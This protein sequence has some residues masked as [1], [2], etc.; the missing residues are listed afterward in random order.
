[1]E[2]IKKVCFYG[3][4][5]TGKTF[6]AK[7]LAEKYKTEFV[8][9]VAREFITTNNFNREDIIVIGRAQTERI[10]LKA[11]TANK[12]LFCDTDLITTQIYSRQYLK[13]VPPVLYELEKMVEFDRYF[14]FDIDVPW[15][16]DGLRDLGDEKKREEMYAIFKIEL[17][18]RNI[19]YVKVQGDWDEREKIIVREVAK[20]IH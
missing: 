2:E 9:E 17:E 5:S 7:K 6:M 1:M 20:L 18:R 16:S 15:V 19:P 10:F 12:I 4:E 8:P 14:L 3:P 13:V 11:R